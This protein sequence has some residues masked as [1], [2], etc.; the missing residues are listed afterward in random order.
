MKYIDRYKDL[1]VLSENAV[2]SYIIDNL[3]DTI[4]TYDFFV[5]WEKVVNNVSEIEVALNILNSL[6]G[7]ENLEDKLRDLII[8]YPEIVPVIPILIAVRSDVIK[9]ADVE[10]DLYYNFK[11]R[12]SYTSQEAA[13]I[14][15]FSR[16]CGLLQMLEDKTIKNLVDYCLGVEV[17][18]DTNARKNR[19]GTAME[20]LTEIYIKALCKKYNYEYIAQATAAKIK[21]QFDKDVPTDKADRHFDF[22]INTDTDIYLIEV[23]YYSGGGSKL[24]SVAGE[25]TTLYQ[26]IEPVE[27]THFIWVTDGRGWL[28]A[29]RPLEETFLSTDYVFNI[30]M[31]EDGLLEEVVTKGL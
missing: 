28:T 4:R 19:S 10:G 25:F 18:L 27:N 6:I 7:K 13:E 16:E 23:N 3:K 24:K 31:I 21:V 5:A 22:A 9:I 1:G 8:T 11:K 15:Y 26:L 30:K 2:F 20:S 29:K 14:V 17:G 12:K